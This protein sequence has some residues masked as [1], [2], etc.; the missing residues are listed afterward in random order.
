MELNQIIAWASSIVLSV[1]V[2]WKVVENWGP[3]VKK[4]V[5]IGGKALT[6]LDKVLTAVEDK[7]VDE[8]EIEAIR[9]EANELMEAI[10]K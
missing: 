8:L 7:K 1:S 9:K 5:S 4:Y 3:K 10:K 2:V 6:L